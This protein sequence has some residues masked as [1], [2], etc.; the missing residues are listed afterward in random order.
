MNPERDAA[1]STPGEVET[2]EEPGISGITLL[3]TALSALV[4]MAQPVETGTESAIE[5]GTVD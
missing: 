2:G 1:N 3:L 5:V 4:P